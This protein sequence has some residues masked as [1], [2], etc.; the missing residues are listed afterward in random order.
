MFMYFWQANIN[1]G[2]VDISPSVVAPVCQT[3]EQLE[4]TCSLTGRFI[5]WEFTVS[6]ESGAPMTL[7][8][9]VTSGGTSGVPLPI[10]VNSTTFTFSRLST[11]PLTSTMTISSVS[12]GLDGVQ[13]NCVNVE[14]SE[15]ASTTVRIVDIGGRKSGRRHS[16]GGRVHGCGVIKRNESWMMIRWPHAHT[17][18]EIREPWGQD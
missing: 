3:G 9:T 17:G 6:L 11:Q 14:V 2:V 4:L 12:E 7:M 18:L 1:S 5:R 16:L 10:T 13:I 15:S 8:P